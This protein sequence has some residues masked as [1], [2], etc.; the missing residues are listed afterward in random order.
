MA[1]ITWPTR[2][3]KSQ[4]MLSLKQRGYQPQPLRRVHISKT[5]WE[6][7][8]LGIPTL[9][10]RTIR[11]LYLL[12]RQFT[13]PVGTVGRQRCAISFGGGVWPRMAVLSRRIARPG[14]PALD[15]PGWVVFPKAI[16]RNIRSRPRPRS[17]L[18]GREDRQNGANRTSQFSQL[19]CGSI[20]ESIA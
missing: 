10:D 4:A 7:P 18:C 19:P 9:K 13:G 20:D 5:N 1:S 14:R 15:R 12:G 2:E 11:A 3:D 17:G 16:A 6:G 8:P